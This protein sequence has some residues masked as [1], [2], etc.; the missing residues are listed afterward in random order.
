MTP[1]HGSFEE[2]PE[3]TGPGRWHFRFWVA[4]ILV[5]GAFLL[6]DLVVLDGAAGLVID[7]KIGPAFLALAGGLWGA[8][9]ARRALASADVEEDR[10]AE[11]EDR[12]LL[13]EVTRVASRPRQL[14][15]LAP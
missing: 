7:W 15:P 11:V 1:E 10:L 13:E 8:R 12:A 2:T 5:A 3:P 14:P 6:T 9:Q 4:V